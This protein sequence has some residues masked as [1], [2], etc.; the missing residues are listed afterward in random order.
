M[1]DK[2]AFTLIELLIVVLIIGILAA[3][4]LPKYQTAAGKSMA[5]EALVNLKALKETVDRYFLETN[6]Y[7]TN[8]SQLDVGF[9]KNCSGSTCVHGNYCYSLQYVNQN[10]IIA[11]AQKCA[12]TQ[13]ELSIFFA[14]STSPVKRGDITCNTRDN[15]NYKKICLALGG[16]TTLSISGSRAYIL[17]R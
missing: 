11:Y 7:P 17:N 9:G 5:A 4:A 1:S 14:D 12:T 13:F 15:D 6:S 10:K 2:K 16:K 3:V 8:F